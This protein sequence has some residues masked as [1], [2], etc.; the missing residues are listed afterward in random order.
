MPNGTEFDPEAPE[1]LSSTVVRG[2]WIAALGYAG[3]QVVTLGFYLVLARLAT[4][5]EFGQLAAGSLVAG[6]GTVITESGMMAALIHRRGSIEVAA[7]TATVATFVGGI[8]F[9]LLALAASPLVGAFFQS[10]TIT[11]VAAVMSGTILLRT[12]DV[13]PEALLQRRFSFVR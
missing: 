9:T 8:T 1:N 6:L 11:A 5:S 2:A 10:S 12:L 13:V 7:N 4:P 3:A